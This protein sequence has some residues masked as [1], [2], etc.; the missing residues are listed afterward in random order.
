MGASHSI[1]HIVGPVLRA[2]NRVFVAAWTFKLRRIDSPKGAHFDFGRGLRLRGLPLV[3]VHKDAALMIGDNVTLNSRNAGYH[4]NMH[5]PVKLFADRAGAT[6][7]IGDM[8]RI[9]GSCIHAYERIE[10]GKYCLIAANCQ[11]FDGNGHDLFP[12]DPRDRINTMGTSSPVA[13]GDAVWIGANA[14]IL[15]GTTIGFGSVVAS[16]AV[17]RGKFGKNSLIAGN[18]AV[19]VREL[20]PRPLTELP[21]ANI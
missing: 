15:P 19:F 7:V 2:L 12:A 10:I 8:S 4:L 3:E 5:S 21:A 14:I 1:R 6:I 16:G 13:I 18:P 11:I 9:H 17:V 20:Q